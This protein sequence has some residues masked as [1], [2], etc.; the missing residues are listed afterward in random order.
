LEINSHSKYQNKLLN[1]QYALAL[2]DTDK[3]L[4]VTICKEMAFHWVPTI[5]NDLL[6]LVEE[7]RQLQDETTRLN[8]QNDSLLQQNIL[9]SQRLHRQ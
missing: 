3:E 9:L 5:L 2:A 7:N 6:L 8:I 1:I 4:I